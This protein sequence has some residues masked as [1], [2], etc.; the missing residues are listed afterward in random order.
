M[1]NVLHLLFFLFFF[2]NKRYIFRLKIQTLPSM[3][4]LLIKQSITQ[5]QIYFLK[6]EKGSFFFKKKKVLDPET[7]ILWN[8]THQSFTMRNLNLKFKLNEIYEQK[9]CKK[10]CVSL[11]YIT[12]K[13]KS[14]TKILM[15]RKKKKKKKKD[16]S[17]SPCHH[18]RQ[19]NPNISLA[20]QI[21]KS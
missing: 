7:K 17:T 1:T 2:L 4:C 14:R 13:Y 3:R 9:K 19:E 12:T 6:K 11:K 21:H 10:F 15:F 8:W 5:I 16:K 20:K 18:N